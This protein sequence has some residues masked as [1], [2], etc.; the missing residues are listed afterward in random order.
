MISVGENYG[1]IIR[2]PEH[3]E[4]IGYSG[5]QTTFYFDPNGA[6]INIGCW[7]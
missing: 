5:F 2:T 6:L 1:E 3:R 7:E 4:H